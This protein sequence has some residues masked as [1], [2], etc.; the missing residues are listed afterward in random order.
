MPALTPANDAIRAINVTA[1]ECYAL[2][3]KHPYATK[4][5]I[6]DRLTSPWDYGRPEQNE[7]MRIGTYMEPYVARYAAKRLG[8][9]VRACTRTIQ[10]P[11]VS[12]CAT[13]DYLILGHDALMEVKVSSITYGWTVDDLHPHYEYQARAQMACT[14]R[15]AVIVVALVGSAFHQVEVIRDLDKE[16][17]LLDAVDS[18]MEEHVLPMIRPDNIPTPLTAVVQERM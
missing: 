13:P 17:R 6:F 7:A 8:I 18:F 4:Q 2:L 12:L 9:K 15:N 3:G 14:N 1:S 10:H 11:K 16:R 5:G